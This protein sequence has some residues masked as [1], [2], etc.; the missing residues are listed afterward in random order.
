MIAT[1]NYSTG[2]PTTS[3]IS[4]VDTGNISTTVT[5]GISNTSTHGTD[6]T[7]HT[8]TTLSSTG[9]YGTTGPRAQGALYPGPSGQVALCISPSVDNI[10]EIQV[11][12]C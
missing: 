11:C 1:S 5:T 6:S 10:S 3:T 12:F 9:R 8:V 4:T 7:S 2:N